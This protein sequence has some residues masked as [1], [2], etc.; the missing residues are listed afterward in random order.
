M[1]TLVVGDVHGCTAELRRLVK[2]SKPDRV[3]LVGDLFT[4]GPDPA[5]M[6]TLLDSNGYEAVLGNHDLRLLELKP[7]D[8]PAL[9]CVKALNKAGGDWQSW[10]AARPLSIEVGPFTVIHAGVHPSGSLEATTPRMAI[11]MR[12]FPMDDTES[13]FWWQQYNGE[14]RVIFGHDARRGLIRITRN[15]QP[16]LIG[17]D[18]GCVYGGRLSGYLVEEDRLFQ[19]PAARTYRAV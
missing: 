18:T 11:Q 2:Q 12:R 7:E 8:K 9:R 5:G 15:Q 16:W 6:W 3:I 1:R 14:R 17:L 4:K 19:V 13:P 10:L